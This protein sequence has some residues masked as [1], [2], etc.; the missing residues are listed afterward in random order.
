MPSLFVPT[1]NQ[2]Q[3]RPSTI[4]QSTG[5]RKSAFSHGLGQDR[6]F[7]SEADWLSLK[8]S[9]PTM[10]CHTNARSFR[11]PWKKGKRD[12]LA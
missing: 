7:R 11:E 10:Q 12:E 9:E 3:R 6:P 2:P 1:T 4:I 5:A 8:Q